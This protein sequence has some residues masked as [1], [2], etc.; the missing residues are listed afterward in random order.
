VRTIPGSALSLRGQRSKWQPLVLLIAL[1]AGGCSGHGQIE[2]SSLNYRAIDP[3]PPRAARLELDRGYWWTD[4]DGQVWIALSGRRQLLCGPPLR[5]DMSLVLEK[6]P[7]GPARNYQVG[8]RELRAMSRWGP[9]ESRFTSVA[10][11][12][13]LYRRPQERLRGSFRL[14]VQRQY[15]QLLG[16]WSGPSSYL[17]QGTFE[18]VHDEKAGQAIAAQTEAYGWEREPAPHSQPQS[19]GPQTDVSPASVPSG[20]ASR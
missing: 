7:A 15:R 1:A 4:A 19:S 14:I 9:T 3:P 13:A 20:P 18:A 11:V 2:L 5:F 10:G 12:V 17:L 6:L 16:G 8:F